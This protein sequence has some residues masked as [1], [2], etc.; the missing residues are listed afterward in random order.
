MGGP[1]KRDRLWFFGALRWW[2]DANIDG[3]RFWNTTQ[4]TPFYTPD[5]NRPGDR[6]EWY[7][8]Y[9]TRVTWQ[10]SPRNK[11]NVFVDRERTCH[12]RDQLS[13]VIAG[14]VDAPEAEFIYHMDPMGLYQATWS[15]PVTNR[16]LLE[17]GA[18][19]ALV[20]FPAAYNPGVTPNDISISEQSTGLTYNARTTYN[21]SDGPRYTQRFSVSYVTGSHA[22][23]SGIQ[24]DEGRNTIDAF[25]NGNVTYR[26]RNGVPVSLTQYAT[27]Y[28][29]TSLTQGGYGDLRAGSVDHQAPDAQLRPAVRLLQ[30]VRARPAGAG[31]PQWL[32]ACAQLRGGDRRAGLE[33][34]E[35]AGRGVV[36]SVRQ[37]PDGAEGVPGPVCGQDRN[38][39]P[40]P[41]TTLSRPR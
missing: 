40:P 7:Q 25:T 8:S 10:A 35:S 2:G 11:V 23:K 15:S 34:P 30:R 24:I 33:G 18:S 32:G 29:L 21:I 36:R 13:P 4:G 5:F 28:V 17:G 16:L 39:N 14:G 38:A 19:A 6:Y 41:P 31:H 26:F 27:P 12:C 20:R 3:G 37:R 9:A 22:F 1:I